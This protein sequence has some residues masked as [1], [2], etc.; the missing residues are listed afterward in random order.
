VPLAGARDAPAPPADPPLPRERSA[1]PLVLPPARLGRRRHG[2]PRSHGPP[3]RK[4]KTPWLRLRCACKPDSEQR[5][6]PALTEK[7]KEQ[8][9]AEGIPGAGFAIFL[10]NEANHTP[11]IARCD[12]RHG[13]PSETTSIETP[14]KPRS[15]RNPRDPASKYGTD[16]QEAHAYTAGR[17]PSYRVRGLLPEGRPPHQTRRSGFGAGIRGSA[18]APGG[19]APACAS[20]AAKCQVAPNP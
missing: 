17:N 13:G 2:F 4:V 15:R 20:R 14:E 6:K 12:P 3:E 9:T 8:T 11:R 7:P 16:E 18:A 5:P 1:R 19:K 10:Q